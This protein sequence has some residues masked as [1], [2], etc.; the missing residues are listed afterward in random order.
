MACAETTAVLAA[1]Q[2]PRSREAGPGAD[3]PGPAGEQPT[4]RDLG[5]QALRR[6]A[7]GVT[8]LTINRD[9]LRHGMTVSAIIAM[10]R[11]PLVLGA[12]LRAQSSFAAMLRRGSRFAVNVLGHTQ[13][14]VADHFA[15]PG[16]PPGDAQFA[17][18]DWSTDRMTGAPLIGGCLAQLACEVTDRRRIGDH[19]LV[20]A[21]VL[22][23]ASTA[24]APLLTY[25]GRLDRS[26]REPAVPVEERSDHR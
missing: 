17:G 14:G 26:A 7:S 8:V 25:A 21:E 1:T 15:D 18:L 10:S 11:E 3:T 22:T 13:A 19:D 12:S 16:R 24:G 20:V 4:A 9:G 23:G 2:P 6:I 5:R